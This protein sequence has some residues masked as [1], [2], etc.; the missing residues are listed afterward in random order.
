MAGKALLKDA[1]SGGRRRNRSIGVGD[2]TANLRKLDPLGTFVQ[3]ESL[4][5]RPNAAASIALTLRHNERV[6]RNIALASAP[7][8]ALTSSNRS[9]GAAVYSFSGVLV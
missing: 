4:A 3:R 7:P 9:A 1:H 8:V 2:V 5:L 6:L